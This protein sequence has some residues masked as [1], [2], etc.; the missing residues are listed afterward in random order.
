MHVEKRRMKLCMINAEGCEKYVA[1]DC[2]AE[3]AYEAV[4]TFMHVF[5]HA[6]TSVCA[7]K[8]MYIC[9]CIYIYIY[10]Y[11]YIYIYIYTHT[12]TYLYTYVHKWIYIDETEQG[13]QRH[14]RERTLEFHHDA[15]FIRSLSGRDRQQFVCQAQ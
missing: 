11:I 2:A 1:Y 13:S 8:C 14:S 10:T 15:L 5:L 3:S 6:H 12:H 9:V 4:S 7:C